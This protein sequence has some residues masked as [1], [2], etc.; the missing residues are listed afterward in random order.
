MLY[1]VMVVIYMNDSENGQYFVSMLS[2]EDCGNTDKFLVRPRIVVVFYLYKK[3]Y[4]A[5]S[6]V[7]S[8]L[9]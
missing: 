2:E 8:P 7:T 3:T 4:R 9:Y 6:L 1:S 5:A